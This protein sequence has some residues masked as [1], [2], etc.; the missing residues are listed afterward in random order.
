MC[1]L[2]Y[3]T[4][5]KK[6]TWPTKVDVDKILEGA[7]HGVGEMSISHYDWMLNSARSIS[8]FST[9]TNAQPQNT[10]QIKRSNQIFSEE[11]ISKRVISELT[12]EIITQTT[13]INYTTEKEIPFLINSDFYAQVFIEENSDLSAVLTAP[14]GD[15][16]S[17]EQS[18]DNTFRLTKEIVTSDFGLWKLKVSGTS[19]LY[20]VM[21]SRNI[22][23]LDLFINTEKS[24]GTLGE[25]IS[26]AA[27]LY[28]INNNDFMSPTPIIDDQL[29]INAKVIYSNGNEELIQLYDDGNHLDGNA[30][31]GF[32]A[33]N[34][35]ELSQVGI[36]KVYLTATRENNWQLQSYVPTEVNV[37][38]VN[39]ST[40]NGNYSENIIDNNSD[41][42]QDVLDIN[43][44]VN[45]KSLG[46]YNITYFL[47]DKDGTDIY[48]ASKSFEAESIG[49]ISINLPVAGSILYESSHQGPYNLRTV[50]LEKYIDGNLVKFD[51]VT[52]AYTT[53][54]T[55]PAV[56]RDKNIEF[57][58]VDAIRKLDEDNDGKTDYLEV[59]YIMNILEPGVYYVQG[60]LNDENNNILEWNNFNHSWTVGEQK[61]TYR[62]DGANIANSQPKELY[63]SNVAVT[64]TVDKQASERYLLDEN[65]DSSTFIL[66]TLPDFKLEIGSKY[67]KSISNHINLVNTG[68]S[69]TVSI[70]V[71]VYYGDPSNSNLIATLTI[72]GINNGEQKALSF[73][74]DINTLGNDLIY[75][76]VNQN[77]TV[78]EVNYT[79]NMISFDPSALSLSTG[80]SNLASIPSLKHMSLLFLFVLLSILTYRQ[81]YRVQ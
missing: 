22:G 23:D 34:N 19:G 33:A 8:G 50:I 81:K 4:T 32:Y 16:L 80:A 5:T 61:F 51:E 30:N 47:T 24:Q 64:G 49:N 59:D 21:V 27:Y 45:I 10:M 60:T 48:N 42:L 17:L 67:T 73:D 53:T 71:S 72:S 66:P 75:I 78:T 36:I 35:L 7:P 37:I 18:N 1:D 29:I 14:N 25:N 15:T 40:L 65:V 38:N 20:Q 79:N 31:D 28:D 74:Y 56:F 57:K 26:I 68:A 43:V 3:L 70:P 77:Q 62:F 2:N 9:V 55:D 58:G 69:T 41:G 76:M 12:D 63:L 11:P 52:N 54:V 46:T 13:L 44:D 6:L 39:E